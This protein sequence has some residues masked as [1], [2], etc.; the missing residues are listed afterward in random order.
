MSAGHQRFER[1]RHR[2]VVGADRK[3]LAHVRDVEQAG[4]LA[5]PGVLREDAVGYCTGMS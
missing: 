2:L 1:A 4:V 3:R 5:H